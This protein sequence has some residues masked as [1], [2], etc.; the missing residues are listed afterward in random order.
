MA[1]IVFDSS[2]L[3]GFLD[4]SDAHHEAAVKAMTRYQQADLVL[5]AS[6]YSEILVG[7]FR[8]NEESVTQIEAFVHDFAMQVHL[9]DRSIARQAALLRSRHVALRLPDAF[10]LATAESLGADAVLT[11]DKSWLKI[12]RRARVV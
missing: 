11:A 2:V 5:P 7:P 12:S 9:I 10:V 1:I 8:R 6:V 4:P 3:I